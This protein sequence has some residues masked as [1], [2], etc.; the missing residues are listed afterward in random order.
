MA[1]ARCSERRGRRFEPCHS[2][3]EG[4][5][6]TRPRLVPAGCDSYRKPSPRI[7]RHPG[8]HVPDQAKFIYKIIVLSLTRVS[9][10]TPFLANHSTHLE[11]LL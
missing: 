9:P 7:G 11:D 8:R 2:D 3:G 10:V 5:S 4:E 6:K 1:S